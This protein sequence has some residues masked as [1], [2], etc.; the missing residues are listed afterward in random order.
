MDA[1]G[2]IELRFGGAAVE[3]HRQSLNDFTGV[4]SDHVAAKHPVRRLIHDQLHHGSF[5][6]SGQRVP[7]RPKQT[8]VDI[9]FEVRVGAPPPRSDPT[10]PQLGVLNT[11]VG[12]F[13]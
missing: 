9:D 10:V 3:R 4:G 11:A 2:R 7:Q 12:T 8:P 6:A 13:R 5:V 1:D